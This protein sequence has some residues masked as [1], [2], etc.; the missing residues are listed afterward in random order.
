MAKVSELT[1]SL[2]EASAERERS[3]RLLQEELREKNVL[4][5]SGEP[6]TADLED[7]LRGRLESVEREVAEKHE[8][9]ETSGAEIAELRE[10]LYAMTGRLYDAEATK[11]ALERFLQ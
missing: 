6:S 8:L 3:D 7:Q 9:L 5:E 1:Q 2:S 10:Q 11:V 4:V